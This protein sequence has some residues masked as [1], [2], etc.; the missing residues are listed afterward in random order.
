MN[1][2]EQLKEMIVG[3]S[4]N[5]TDKEVLER[6]GQAI[7]ALRAVEN[8]VF[9]GDETAREMFDEF[10]EDVNVEDADE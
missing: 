6:A 5:W 8:L 1:K 7:D 9:H 3:D 2:Y 4:D 10:L